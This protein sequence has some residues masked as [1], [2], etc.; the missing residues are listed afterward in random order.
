[1]I[2]INGVYVKSPN[3]FQPTISDLDGNTTRTAN[4]TLVRDRIAVKRKLQMSWSALTPAELSTLL[5]AVSPLF[6]DVTYPDPQTG[7]R[8]TKTFYVGD[9]TPAMAI[10]GDGSNI[11]WENLSMNFIEK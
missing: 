3:T 1:M 4:G 11:I 10:Y 7:T 8:I 2:Q 9:R 6:F 5:T